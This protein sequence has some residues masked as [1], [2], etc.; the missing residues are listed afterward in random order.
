MPVGAIE[1]MKVQAEEG[2]AG[3]PF[4]P[5]RIELEEVGNPAIPLVAV[6]FSSCGTA[7][8]LP[9]FDFRIRREGDPH[10]IEA[11]AERGREGQ[12]ARVSAGRPAW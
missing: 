6:R 7:A 4:A 10:R 5:D 12:A 2:E 8:W 9:G 3:H 11:D 1:A